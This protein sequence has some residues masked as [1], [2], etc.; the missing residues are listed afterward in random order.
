MRV[1]KAHKYDFLIQNWCFWG[2]GKGWLHWRENAFEGAKI[3]EIPILVHGLRIG[4][5]EFLQSIGLIYRIRSSEFH[6]SI[7]LARSYLM[8]VVRASNTKTSSKKSK[9]MEFSTPKM[10][11]SCY[12]GSKR[13]HFWE[14][15]FGGKTP[16]G[17]QNQWNSNFGSWFMNWNLGISPIDWTYI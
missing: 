1:S 12:F 16:W 8:A 6:R 11:K 3:N 13:K 9:I 5:W 2:A 10:L 7:A 4:I 17:C 15:K 14:P